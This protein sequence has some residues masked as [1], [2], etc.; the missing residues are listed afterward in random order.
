LQAQGLPEPRNPG[1]YIVLNDGFKLRDKIVPGGCSRAIGVQG[2][3]TLEVGTKVHE[4][5]RCLMQGAFAADL[6]SSA[7]A[8]K[9][10]RKMYQAG[11]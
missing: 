3:E 11:A 6:Q 1:F 4:V 9:W 5:A 10:R 7:G 2:G 8:R